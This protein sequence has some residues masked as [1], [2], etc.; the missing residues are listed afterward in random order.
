MNYLLETALT[1]IINQIKIEY[2]YNDSMCKDKYI[3]F[4]QDLL[5]DI[6]ISRL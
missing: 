6:I 3:E 5:Y 4:I 2:P 1:Q